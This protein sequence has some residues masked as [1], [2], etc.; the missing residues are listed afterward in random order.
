VSRSGLRNRTLAPILIGLLACTVACGPDTPSGPN[1][2]VITIDTVRADRIGA[3]GHTLRDITPHIDALADESVLFENA[4]ASSSFTPPTHASIFTGLHPSEH[5]MMH[6]NKPLGD[7]PTAAALFRDA[8]WNTLA[9]SPLPTL[10]KLGLDR[11]FENT[12]SPPVRRE[13]DRFILADADALSAAALPLLTAED[14]RPFFAW[15]HYYDAHRPYGRQGPEWSG[16]YAA[17]D[18]P[19]IGAT[20]DYYQLTPEK[21][22][23][24]GLTPAQTTLMRDHYDGGLAYLD[25][26]LGRLF[27]ALRTAGVLEDTIVV[28]IADHGEVLDEYE[29]EWFSHDPWL[30]DEN[31]HVP[32]LL[33]L[34]GAAHAGTRVPGLVSQVD[35]LPTLLALA[36]VD[37]PPDLSGLD[38]TRVIEG[39]ALGRALVFADRIGDDLSARKTDTPPTE[40]EVAASRDRRRMVRGDR[41]KLHHAVD[42]DQ[43]A[44]Y[45]VDGSTPEGEDVQERDV[46]AFDRLL[47]AYRDLLESLRPPPGTPDGATGI[48]PATD[49]FLRGIGY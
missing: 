16:R 49:E 10:F 38:L 17:D 40:E 33:R 24:L 2:L 43:V 32:F 27:D 48:D 34:P 6:W 20:E 30:V 46:A 26:R 45:A 47:D 15:I 36:G 21:R 28:V 9:V 12:I 13:D 29:A 11:G 19:S 7:V 14:G 22:A 42:R 31:T 41:H 4:F 23:A 3:Y 25:D 35:V 1:V 8:G 5:G 18:D 37:A 44:L 39:G